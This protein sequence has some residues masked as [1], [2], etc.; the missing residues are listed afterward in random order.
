MS[1]LMDPPSDRPDVRPL[2]YLIMPPWFNRTYPKIY[3]QRSAMS[4]LI[5]SKNPHTK[6]HN[7]DPNPGQ[8]AASDN[9]IKSDKSFALI[10]PLL[11]EN[12]DNKSI[13]IYG[14]SIDYQHFYNVK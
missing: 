12:R 10:L 9:L 8:T 5:N 11:C 3:D 2:Y 1:A 6:D 4:I 13:I 7:R 14:K